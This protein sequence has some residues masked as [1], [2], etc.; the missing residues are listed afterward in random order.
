MIYLSTLPCGCVV[1]QTAIYKWDHHIECSWCGATFD[2][3]EYREWDAPAILLNAQ[4]KRLFKFGPSLLE[5]AGRCGDCSAPVMREKPG[6]VKFHMPVLP[7]MFE[8]V[9]D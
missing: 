8:R 3:R 5:F 4:P 2:F 6:A 7:T 9:W 1:D